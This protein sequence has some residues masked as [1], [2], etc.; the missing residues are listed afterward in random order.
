MFLRSQAKIVWLLDGLDESTNSEL[1]HRFLRES[2][3][4]YSESTFIVLSR[5]EGKETLREVRDHMVEYTLDKLDE[6]QCLQFVDVFPFSGNAKEMQLKKEKLTS[7]LETNS[8]MKS[9]FSIPINAVM[10]CRLFDDNGFDGVVG[11]GVDIFMKLLGSIAKACDD[12]L[13]DKKL[14]TCEKGKESDALSL[15]KQSHKLT[16]VQYKKGAI[17][18]RSEYDNL[19]ACVAAF[20]PEVLNGRIT[21]LTAYSL[22]HRIGSASPNL[23]SARSLVRE[24]TVPFVTA[25]SATGHLFSFEKFPACILMQSCQGKDTQLGDFIRVTDGE[26]RANFK[27]LKTICIDSTMIKDVSFK[28]IIAWLFESC[29]LTDAYHVDD[30][31]GFLHGFWGRFSHTSILSIGLEDLATG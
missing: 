18:L 11:N 26:K 21:Q 28:D 14:I 23:R 16:H 2:I 15:E 8:S 22:Q 20:K 27:T 29:L 4:L 24:I 10:I 3:E 12:K 31:M 7:A 1:M 25:Q 19:A 6:S 5:E 13:L 17:F 30:G 9:A